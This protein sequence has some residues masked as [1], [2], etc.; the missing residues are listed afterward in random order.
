MNVK[1]IALSFLIYSLYFYSCDFD[2]I[3]HW[4]VFTRF[5]DCIDAWMETPGTFLIKTLI[6][7]VDANNQAS[8]FIL[9]WSIFKS[10]FYI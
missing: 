3:I 8:P 5:I 2:V 10:A 6:R 1:F 9:L 7:L 4:F